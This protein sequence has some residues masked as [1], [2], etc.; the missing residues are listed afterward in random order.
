MLENQIR[1][2]AEKYCIILIYLFGSEAKRGKIY[3]EGGKVMPHPFSDLDVAVA[4]EKAPQEPMETYGCLY[5]EISEVFFP[6]N[7][8]LLF[9]QEVD[10]LFQYEIIKGIRIYVSDEFVADEFEEGIMKMSEGLLFKKRVL[11]L[12]IMETVENGYIEIEYSPNSS[13]H[14]I[15]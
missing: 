8:D 5:R 13:T 6:F 11:D 7:V 10:T 4:F 12:D 15:Y 2:I 3:F 14:Q 9:M 1:A